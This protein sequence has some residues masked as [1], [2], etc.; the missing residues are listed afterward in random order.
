MK[1]EKDWLCDNMK[2]EG[3]KRL[4]FKEEF[5]ESFLDRISWKMKE[6]NI[7]YSK[8]AVFLKCSSRYV[9]QLF[10][11]EVDLSA[12]TMYDLA[13]FTGINITIEMK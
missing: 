4:Y 9:E 1:I 12:S 2:D 11:R 8:M 10:K 5:I 13:Y 6:R 7:S 3:F